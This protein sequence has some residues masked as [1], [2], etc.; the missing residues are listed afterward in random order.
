MQFRN[1]P[2]WTVTL[3]EQKEMTTNTYYCTSCAVAQVLVA[4]LGFAAS[5]ASGQVY[6]RV[7][8]TS[9]EA[10]IYTASVYQN[11]T[12]APAVALVLFLTYDSSKATLLPESASGNYV[13]LAQQQQE[14]GFVVSETLHNTFDNVE[15]KSCLAIAIYK[16]N[17]TI[18]LN[19]GE[20][21]SFQLQID[22]DTDDATPVLIQAA[23]AAFPV[24]L[25]GTALVSSASTADEISL[26]VV[27]EPASI[28]RNCVPPPSPENVKA[29]R[30]YKDKI[31]ITWEPPQ[32]DGALEYKLYRGISDN[33]TEAIPLDMSYTA[34][35]TWTDAFSAETTNALPAGCNC[36]LIQ[37][38]YWVR[39]RDTLTGCLS[40]FSDPPARGAL[41]K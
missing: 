12:E 23:T 7:E 10:G 11:A 14:A 28:A 35:A 3:N 31:V 37:Y 34:D 24:Y 8:T 16:T 1:E 17:D 41:R 5:N 15:G 27:F 4:L 20:L 6:L 9:T 18:G 30:R 25:S 13:Q 39:A 26:P 22:P 21:F 29:S 32:S 19:P 36:T 40:T 2:C 38:Y 33:I